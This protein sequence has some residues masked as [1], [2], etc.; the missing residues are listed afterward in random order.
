ML[1]LARGLHTAP[2]TAASACGP[3]RITDKRCVAMTCVVRITPAWQGPLL[4]TVRL[5]A[6]ER[7]RM[8][9]GGRGARRLLLAKQRP[10]SRGSPIKAGIQERLNARNTVGHH[11]HSLEG[12]SLSHR[13]VASWIIIIS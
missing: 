13:S 11:A 6:Q 5:L 1:I 3:G 9:R 2:E 4:S 7:Y 8:L 10:R 12:E